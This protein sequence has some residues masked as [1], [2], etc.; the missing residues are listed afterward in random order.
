[1]SNTNVNGSS[2]TY[3]TTNY[4]IYDSFINTNGSEILIVKLPGTN[5]FVV[6][7]E[8]KNSMPSA[9]EGGSKRRKRTHKK[10]AYR[11]SRTHKRR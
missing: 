5:K 1:M 3:N 9:S 2:L 11:K 7:R 4:P 6:D 10:R 8:H